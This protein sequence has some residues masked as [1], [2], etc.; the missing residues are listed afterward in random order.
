MKLIEKL[1][2]NVKATQ[3]LRK[4]LRRL[5]RDKRNADKAAP[6]DNNRVYRGSGKFA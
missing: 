5:G 6:T 1:E 4:E 3:K 2:R